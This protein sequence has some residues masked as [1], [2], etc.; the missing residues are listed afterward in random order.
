MKISGKQKN[1]GITLIALVITIIVLLILAGVTIATLTGENGILTKAGEAREQTEI[2]EVK[3]LARTDVM[4]VQTENNGKITQTQFKQILNK[5]FDE[6]PESLPED[7]SSLILTT[8]KEYGEHEINISDIW[9]GNFSRTIEDLKE[10]DFVKYTDGKGI[11]RKCIVLYDN[12]SGYGV[13]IITMETVEDVTLGSNDETVNGE[14]DFEKAMNSYNNAIDKLNK[15]AEEYINTT[16][17]TDARSVG[18]VP[19][20]KN[21]E[22]D[23]LTTSYSYMESYNGKLRDE[24]SNYRTDYEK[25]NELGIKVLDEEYWLASRQLTSYSS[26]GSGIYFYISGAD[27]YGRSGIVLCRISSD[28]KIEARTNEKGLRPIFTLRGGIKIENGKG[29]ETEPY[30]LEP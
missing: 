11:E 5:Y 8:K 18:S 10:G 30:V 19:N 12:N 17:V 20:D 4:G 14:T 26:R 21:S 7:L 23:F 6:V 25:M 15:K 9:N 24:D 2:A 1:K 13:Q 29:T 16:Y 3:E 22:S 27:R 28:G